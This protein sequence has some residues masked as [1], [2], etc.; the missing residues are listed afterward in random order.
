[1]S[2]LQVVYLHVCVILTALTGIVFAAMKY[3]M[4]PAGDFAVINHPLQPYML[5]AHVVIAPFVLFG[6]GW[7]FGNHIWPK[8]VYRD[9]RKRS[10]G[11]WS[12]SAIVPMTLS[13]YLMQVSTA[14][15]TR[16]AMAIA[17]WLT[18]ALF[19]AAYVAHWITRSIPAAGRSAAEDGARSVPSPR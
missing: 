15:A 12:M 10:S 4:N 17:H 7:V 19:L 5:S 8:F 3:F 13:G 11:I 18:S 6:F 2:R 14:D 16:R 1:M 9:A